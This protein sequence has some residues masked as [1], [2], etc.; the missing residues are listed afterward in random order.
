[1]FVFDNDHLKKKYIYRKVTKE[2]FLLLYLF[3]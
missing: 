1:M 2:Q 3:C